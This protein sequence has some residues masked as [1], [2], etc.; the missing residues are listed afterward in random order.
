MKFY[1]PKEIATLL[2]V[3]Y[4]TIL[5][6]IVVGELAAFKIGRQYRISHTSLMEYIEHHQA[7][8]ISV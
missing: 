8:N 2:S 6:R 1:T 7:E 4:R 3:N 5:D